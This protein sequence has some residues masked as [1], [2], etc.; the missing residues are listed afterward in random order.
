LRKSTS[1]YK[2]AAAPSNRFR[3]RI[4]VEEYIGYGA[5]E[6]PHVEMF[7]YAR[8]GNKYRIVS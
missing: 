4:L 8:E 6:P 7:I 5:I 1:Q 3:A 2:S